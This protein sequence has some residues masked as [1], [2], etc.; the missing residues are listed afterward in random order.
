MRVYAS[1]VFRESKEK[2]RAHAL[3][4]FGE[5]LDR[6]RLGS[7]RAPGQRY[8]PTA[9][10]AVY[11]SLDRETPL[12]ELLRTYQRLL[13]TD[14]QEDIASRRVMFTA[15]VKLQRVVDQRY[16]GVQ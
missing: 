12:R 14:D 9:I 3:H 2:Y 7:M 8:N 11:F 10:G 4:D 1:I 6:V 13:D 15:D 16:R 5:Y